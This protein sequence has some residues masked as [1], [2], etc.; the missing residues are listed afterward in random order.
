MTARDHLI[1]RIAEIE[2]DLR[3][4][5]RSATETRRLQDERQSKLN[6]LRRLQARDAQADHQPAH[7]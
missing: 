6:E 1:N 4:R 3:H 5:V 7:D 2:V